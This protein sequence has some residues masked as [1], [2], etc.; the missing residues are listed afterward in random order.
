MIIE[1]LLKKEIVEKLH[2][3]EIQG[4]KKRYQ[5]PDYV[6]SL[7][8]ILCKTFHNEPEK[9]RFLALVDNLQSDSMIEFLSSKLPNYWDIDNLQDPLAFSNPLASS[10]ISPE[11]YKKINSQLY[12]L[13]LHIHG[14]KGQVV[15]LLI[16]NAKKDGI[17]KALSQ[18]GYS[19]AI[20]KIAPDYDTFVNLRLGKDTIQ[21]SEE[22]LS[23]LSEEFG[24]PGNDILEEGKTMFTELQKFIRQVEID[25]V[26]D[27]A[28]VIY[29]RK[30]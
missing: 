30:A 27:E 11:A 26:L 10:Q 17:E 22:Y 23:W 19:D 2:A 15:T 1:G 13:L 25:Y 16:N 4:Y 28:D 14:W 18:E 12:K 24:T 7:V 9:K 21:K 20:R 5:N 6:Q 29:H 8:Q 3:R